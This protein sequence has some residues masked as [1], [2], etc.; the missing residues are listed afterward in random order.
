MSL[1]AS[2]NP[3]TPA[4]ILRKTPSRGKGS[5][6]ARG[7]LLSKVR[8]GTPQIGS[9]TSGIGVHFAPPENLSEILSIASSKKIEDAPNEKLNEE[10]QGL[11]THLRNAR[12]DVLVDWL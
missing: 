1:T 6:M 3:S 7:G 12:G 11:L 10:I 4:G 8:N 9:P 2:S 5:R